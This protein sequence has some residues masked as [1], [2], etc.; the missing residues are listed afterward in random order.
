MVERDRLSLSRLFCEL[1]DDNGQWNDTVVSFLHYMFPKE[2][3]VRALS[4]LESA[5]VTIYV[6]GGNGNM[7]QQLYED[8]VLCRLVV[9][10]N[11]APRPILVDLA[12]WFCSC[13]EYTEAIIGHIKLGTLDTTLTEIDDLQEFSDDKFAQV[14][15][16]SLSRQ[17]Y[18]QYEQLLCPHLLAYSILLRSRPEI[19]RHFANELSC[20]PIIA[21]HNMDEWLKLHINVVV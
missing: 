9:D 7:V 5:T 20:V 1:L 12:H 18:A 8:E 13:S 19:L 14:D 21:V 16:H 6:L 17:R 2:L 11:G 3:F 10:G 15:A 4:L